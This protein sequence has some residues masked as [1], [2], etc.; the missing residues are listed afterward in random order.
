MPMKCSKFGLLISDYVDGLLDMD[1]SAEVDWHIS[2]CRACREEVEVEKKAMQL[3]RVTDSPLPP[4][5]LRVI[6]DA[7][8]AKIAADKPFARRSRRIVVVGTVFGSSI[9]LLA[10]S[11]VLA[12]ILHH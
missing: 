10:I 3:L 1:T 6:L 4:E 7:V 8:D 5:R 9:L 12:R 2:N 11:L